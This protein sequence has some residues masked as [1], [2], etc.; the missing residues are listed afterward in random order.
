MLHYLRQR[1]KTE[2]VSVIYPDFK[3]GEYDFGVQVQ[4]FAQIKR[5]TET[6]P[7]C[8]RIPLVDKDQRL[9]SFNWICEHALEVSSRNQGKVILAADEAQRVSNKYRNADGFELIQE[10]GMYG[11]DLVLTTHRPSDIHASLRAAA[12]KVIVFQTHH[13]AD[14]KVFQENI[15]VPDEV[16]KGLKTDDYLE[17][18]VE[19]GYRIISKGEAGKWHS[20]NE[21]S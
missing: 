10:N 21:A 15:D 1:I 6:R 5:A 4:T 2:H 14:V 13:S 7:F 17:W 9:E 12:D 8:L 16:F 19:H 11:L 18:D 3:G 20:T